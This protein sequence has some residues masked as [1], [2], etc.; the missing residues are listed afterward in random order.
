MGL[1]NTLRDAKAAEKWLKE[2]SYF[3]EMMPV[4]QI[5]P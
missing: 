5:R 2:L 4:I 1:P 3:L